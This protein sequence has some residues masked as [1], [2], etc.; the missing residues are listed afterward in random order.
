MPTIDIPDKIC[1]HCNGIRWVVSSEKAPTKNDP[2]KRR[3][4][5]TCWIKHSARLLRNKK[6]RYAALSED[7]K[8]Q[9]QKER[10]KTYGAKQLEKQKE[11]RKEHRLLNPILEKPE[12]SKEE[13]LIENRL[14]VKYWYNLNK[15]RLDIIEKRKKKDKKRETSLPT[16]FMYR[17]FKRR[18]GIPKEDVTLD[19]VHKYKTY[20]LALRQLKQLENEEKSN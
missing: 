8:R 5:Y 6:R 14:R 19:M 10:Y 16:S 9:I 3:I 13:K 18:L 2:E 11:K 20:L 15:D 17:L 7:E 4:K 1:K 12:K